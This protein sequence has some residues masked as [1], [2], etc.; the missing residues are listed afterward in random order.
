MELAELNQLGRKH[1][2]EFYAYALR[3]T[4]DAERAKDLVQDTIYTVLKHHGTFQDGTSFTAWVRTIIK[5]IFT[6]GYRKQKRRRALLDANPPRKAWMVDKEVIN[7]AIENLLLEDLLQFVDELPE[8][9]RST[10]L[11]H[12]R[13]LRHEDIALRTGVVVGTSK[14]RLFTA[15]KLL[16]R[17]MAE[18]Y[19]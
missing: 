4:G 8:P 15:R 13:G 3:L 12:Y 9:Y 7:P 14:S 17:R 2:Q 5:N 16:Q 18:Q 1:H 6:S 10:F 11:L 19:R